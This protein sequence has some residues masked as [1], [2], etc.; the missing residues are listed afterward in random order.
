MLIRAQIQLSKHSV[1]CFPVIMSLSP[2]S[3]NN[4]DCEAASANRMHFKPACQEALYSLSHSLQLY[5]LLTSVITC[6]YIQVFFSKIARSCFAILQL[7][8][9]FSSKVSASHKYVWT[10]SLYCELDLLYNFANLYWETLKFF[11][12]CFPLLL[13]LKPS[14]AKTFFWN[15]DI[16][17]RCFL[18]QDGKCD[19]YKFKV[20]TSRKLPDFSH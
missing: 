8:L 2:P 12:F 19:L 10:S 6:D 3:S 1:P 17:E 5:S 7:H 15:Y 13:L 20:K 14:R 11:S 9:S 18:S 16:E 4:P